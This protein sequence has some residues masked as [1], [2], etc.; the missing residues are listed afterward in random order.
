MILKHDSYLNNEF[1]LISLKIRQ[2]STLQQ[3][4]RLKKLTILLLHIGVTVEKTMESA[5]Q[6]KTVNESPAHPQLILKDPSGAGLC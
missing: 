4:K 3:M 2:V 5:M 1:C 6:M